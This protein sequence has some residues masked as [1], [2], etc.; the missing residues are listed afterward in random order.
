[1]GRTITVPG[2]GVM[3][4]EGAPEIYQTQGNPGLCRAAQDEK[5]C[6]IGPGSLCRIQTMV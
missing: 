2:S 3:H 6:I 1:M 5:V 4:R